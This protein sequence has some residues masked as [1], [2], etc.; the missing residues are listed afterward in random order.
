MFGCPPYVLIQFCDPFFLHIHAHIHTHRPLSSVPTWTDPLGL[1]DPL[2]NHL[3]KEKLL[4]KHCCRILLR[5]LTCLYIEMHHA[6]NPPASPRPPF[7]PQPPPEPIQGSMKMCG[8][9]IDIWGIQTYG[10]H[11]NMGAPN[12][13]ES[14]NI[15]G[16][17]KV[18]LYHP[19]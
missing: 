10:G 11:L 6:E 16:T 18:Q 8:E 4:P 7:K 19:V 5:N 1:P 13:W 12:I 9:H 15:W 3:R 17:S 2:P 14:P